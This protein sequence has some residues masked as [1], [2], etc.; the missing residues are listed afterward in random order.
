MNRY[1][2]DTSE[3]YYKLRCHDK[4]D[5][6]FPTGGNNK[7]ST[8]AE[9][10]RLFCPQGKQTKYDEGFFTD[11]TTGNSVIKG[12]KCSA[13]CSTDN[14][15]VEGCIDKCGTGKYFTCKISG[16]EHCLYPVWR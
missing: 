10:C 14:D 16:K 9:Y 8:D 6:V 1:N 11:K 2:M 5:Q 7:T 3:E 15:T 4:S 13:A 12:T